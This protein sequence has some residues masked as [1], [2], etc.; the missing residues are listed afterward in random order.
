MARFLYMDDRTNTVASD[1]GASGDW[2]TLLKENTRTGGLGAVALESPGKARWQM[3]VGSGV[4]TAPV[5][6]EGKLYVTSMQGQLHAI[7]ADNGRQEWKFGAGAEIYSTP[8]LWRGFFF[9]WGRDE[10]GG[11]G[12]G[13]RRATKE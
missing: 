10:G 8:S 5:W 11:A 2:V 1:A 12:E 7:N 13:G 9:F 4:R 6:R 3:R